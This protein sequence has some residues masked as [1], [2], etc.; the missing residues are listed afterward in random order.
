MLR[1]VHTWAW[2]STQ[3]FKLLKGNLFIKRGEYIPL[4]NPGEDGTIYEPYKEPDKKVIVKPIFTI[5][6]KL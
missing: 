5:L 4:M 2:L 1:C 3:H 6:D